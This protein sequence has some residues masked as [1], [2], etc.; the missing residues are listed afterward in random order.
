MRVLQTL[1]AIVLSLIVTIIATGI[2]R[3]A[4]DLVGPNAND[5]WLP[6][7]ISNYFFRTLGA[8]FASGA[9]AYLGIQAA[10]KV[11][12]RAEI[13]IVAWTLAGL[14][15]LLFVG[16][17]VVILLHWQFP[18]D[19]LTSLAQLIGTCVGAAEAAREIAEY[20]PYPKQG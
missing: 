15:A 4:Y 1:G 19:F 7:A 3:V 11:F 18:E 14:Y 8:G 10:A 6:T 16:L 13:P 20:P 2:L 17:I 5:S 12:R 9:G